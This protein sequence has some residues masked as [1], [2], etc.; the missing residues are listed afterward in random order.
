MPELKDHQCPNAVTVILLLFQ[1]F[2]HPARHC[3]T[4]K[5]PATADALC[6]EQVRHQRSKRATEPVFQWNAKALLGLAQDSFRQTAFH[7]LA[8]YDFGLSFS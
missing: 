4:I 8:E 6:R 7:R 1:M 5:V 3:L 2:C